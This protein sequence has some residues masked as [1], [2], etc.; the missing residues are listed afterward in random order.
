MAELEKICFTLPWSV[1]QCR[2][3]LAQ[4]AFAAFGLWH[5]R[6]LAAYISFYHAAGEMEILNLAVLPPWRRLGLGCRILA[7]AL[8]AARKMG[9]EKA[10]LEVRE[11]NAA[12]IALYRKAGFA[13]CGRRLKYYPD[14]GEDALI[15]IYDLQAA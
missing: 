4:A 8:Q 14:T 13:E 7:L 15:F 5:G 6:I 1:E 10:S 2:G 11:G 12:A 9:M 3:A